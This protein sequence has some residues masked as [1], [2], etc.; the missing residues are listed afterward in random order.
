MITLAQ[1][2]QWTQKYCNVT[3]IDHKGEQFSV[4]IRD[5]DGT[6]LW[7]EWNFEDCS[8]LIKCVQ[9]YGIQRELYAL[10]EVEQ[11]FDE[12]FD[13]TLCRARKVLQVFDTKD[14]ADFALYIFEKVEGEDDYRVMRVVPVSKLTESFR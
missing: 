1:A 8:G 7:S 5:Q 10:C 3:I 9:Q 12:E 2:Q 13:G 4:E 11:F 14:Q 6:L